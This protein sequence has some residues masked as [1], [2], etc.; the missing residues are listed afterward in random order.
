M[1]LTAKEIIPDM[2]F[3][4]D[5]EVDLNLYGARYM[6]EKFL[7]I[8]GSKGMVN[9]DCLFEILEMDLDQARDFLIG[10]AGTNADRAVPDPAVCEKVG[11]TLATLQMM[12]HVYLNEQ[13][14][15]S[16]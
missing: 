7:G 15:H 11:Q 8:F 2:S 13:I 12:I 9:Q 6:L 1:K 10:D 16:S 4:S 14:V 5:G 3:A